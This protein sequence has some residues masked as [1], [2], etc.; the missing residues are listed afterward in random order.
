MCIRKT[1]T[2]LNS[3]IENKRGHHTERINISSRH[4]QCEQNITN[5][6]IMTDNKAL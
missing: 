2:Q 3:A 5:E 1:N 4:R 6:I